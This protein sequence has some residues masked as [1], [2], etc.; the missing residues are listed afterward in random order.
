[1]TAPSLC[2]DCGIVHARPSNPEYDAPRRETTWDYVAA[3]VTWALVLGAVVT[4][5]YLAAAW[6]S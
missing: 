6:A 1:M 2:K 4:F 5:F 3:F